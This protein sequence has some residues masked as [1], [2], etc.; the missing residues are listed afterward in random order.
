MKRTIKEKL[1]YL[2]YLNI[3]TN[4]LQIIKIWSQIKIYFRVI[5]LKFQAK[6]IWSTENLIEISGKV[7]SSRRSPRLK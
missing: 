5:I 6:K 4:E 3:F 2:N 7:K 1:A